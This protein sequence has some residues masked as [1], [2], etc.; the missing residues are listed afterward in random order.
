MMSTAAGQGTEAFAGDGAPAVS[1]SLDAPRSVAIS[2]A[3]LLTLADT[4][5]ARIRQ[6]DNLPA[7][8]PDIHTIA[9]LGVTNSSE[10]LA[11]SGPSV[12]AYGSGVLTATI[13]SPT[14]ASGPVTFLDTTTSTAVTLGTVAL[15]AG[16]ATFSTA[17]LP[18]GPHAI[19]A[20]YAGDTGHA[21][22][23]SSA[24]ALTV[25][26][27]AATAVP[28]AASVLYGQAI[29]MLSG[30]VTGI[31]PQD[32]T[33]VSA[34]F[35]T[36]AAALSPS[37][38]YSISAVL[39]GPSAM[40][41]TLTTAPASLTIAPAPTLTM[42]SPSTA[43]PAMGQPVTVAL[44]AVSTTSGTPT[45]SVSLYDGN[46]LL[47]TLPL[48]NGAAAFAT[49]ALSVGGH[50]LAATYSGDNNFL[51]SSSAVANV[52]VGPAADFTLT[53]TGATSQ[54]VPSGS[55]ATYSFAVAAQGAPLTSPIALA[56]Q[57]L[58][59]GATAS[60]NP[61][62][63]PPGAT[64]AAFTLTIQTA[65]LARDVPPRPFAPAGPLAALVL[66]GF[67]AFARGRGG[68]AG[69]YTGVRRKLFRASTAACCILWATLLGGCG[70]RVNPAPELAT[71]TA[72]TVTVTAT[73]TSPAGAALQ[74][75]VD[76]TLQVL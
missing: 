10:T 8:G 54:S 68:A 76:V 65:K 32:A 17:A 62:Y 28:N 66:P 24:F 30:T 70:N 40:D 15:T 9:G 5:N 26:P 14:A 27:L 21:P 51:A 20:T 50:A 19:L 11:L 71:A 49:S 47:A 67:A 29:P 39:T 59:P 6:L 53:V 56:V 44:Q 34:V 72:Y 41:Y 58:P 2:P 52:T 33:L 55:P 43:N 46:A 25:T 1:A 16:V 37:G 61:A 63:V 18:A 74:H 42:V 36:S 31:L 13:A 12:T 7:P 48:G 73:A 38:V 57:G 23:E 64:P 45:G 22:A 3:G 4:G 69:R 60:M 35:T 75:S